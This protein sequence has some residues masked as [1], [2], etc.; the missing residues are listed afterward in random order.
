MSGYGAIDTKD[1]DI[2]NTEDTFEECNVYYLKERTLTAKQRFN[3]LISAAVP[4]LIALFLVGGF[5]LWL[6]KDFGMLYPG[7]SGGSNPQ[8]SPIRSPSNFSPRNEP[9]PPIN[10]PVPNGASSVVSSPTAPT[11]AP[12]TSSSSS[13]FSGGGHSSC[14]ANSACG[15]LGLTGECCPTNAGIMLGCCSPY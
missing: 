11:P 3:K 15:D 12:K 13:S 7:P 1:G 10:S 4:L 6:L 9:A 2:S 14:G 8:N 5:A